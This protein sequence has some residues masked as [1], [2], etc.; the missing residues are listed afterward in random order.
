MI[1]HMRRVGT[2][3][4]EA[5]GP[6]RFLSDINNKNACFQGFKFFWLLP[7]ILGRAVEYAADRTCLESSIGYFPCIYCC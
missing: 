3:T 6:L 7:D 4:V 1:Q 5:E 2:L